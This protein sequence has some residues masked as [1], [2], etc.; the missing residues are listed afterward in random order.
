MSLARRNGRTRVAIATTVVPVRSAIYCRKSTT[1]GLDSDF[2][3]IDNQRAR[4]EAFAD[5]QGWTVLA[6][7]YDDG[8]FSGATMERPALKALLSDVD[9][10][11][12]D[13]IIVYRLDRLSRSL[14]DFCRL[15]EFLETRG[16]ALVSVTESINTTTP[17]GRMIVNVLA[18][19]SQYERELT[20]ARTKD[21]LGAARRKGKFT[22]GFP[23][24]GFD[25]DPRGGRLIPNEAEAKTVREVFA[26][27]LERRSLVLVAEELRRRNVTLKRWLTRDG[28]EYGGGKFNKTNLKRLLTNYAYVGQVQFE[29]KLFAAE[30]QG[31]VSPKLFREVQAVL[32]ENRGN[33]GAGTRNGQGFLLRGLVRCTACDASMVPS[34]TRKAHR[35]YRYYTCGRAQKQGHA[36]CPTKSV[37]ADAIEKFVVDQIRRIG[38][39]PG[40]QAATFEQAVAQVAAQRRGC[41]AETTRLTRN[42]SAAHADVE[43]LVATLS[44]TTGPAAEAVRGELEKA[45]EHV[46]ILEARLAEVHTQENALAAQHVDEADLAQALQDF[47]ELWSALLTPE[48]ER[49]IQLL[50]EAIRYDGATGKLDIDWRLSGFG[51]LAEEVGGA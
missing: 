21:K 9:A 33:G 4:A 30:H 36:T 22:G 8:G 17:H 29:G 41:K 11:R 46:A 27:F 14:A 26:L 16:V 19:F 20:S 48:K 15:H 10:G 39:D 31:I 23:I 37:K 2:S 13:T 51:E 40:L 50:V 38:A 1:E 49:I 45:Q 5:S 24:L 47:D 3:S 43:R 42:L 25:L 7:R 6:D 34:W 44:R 35:T 32:E 18:S 28:R 12:V